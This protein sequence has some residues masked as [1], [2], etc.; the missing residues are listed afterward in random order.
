MPAQNGRS[1]WKS[2]TKAEFMKASSG[3]EVGRERGGRSLNFVYCVSKGI[4]PYLTLAGRL[5]AGKPS[6]KHSTR[7]LCSRQYFKVK[8]TL[9]NILAKS[10]PHFQHLEVK[11]AFSVKRESIGNTRYV[12]ETTK[13]FAILGKTIWFR[14]QSYVRTPV[15]LSLQFLL[16]SARYTK[17]CRPAFELSWL[18]N[19]WL[20][21][22]EKLSEKWL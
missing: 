4:F 10:R 16:T 15:I 2:P 17:E 20:P 12:T 1:T 14:F 22:L 8:E 5:W 21:N 18:C 6:L 7:D 19:N 13:I 11:C 3:W 9:S